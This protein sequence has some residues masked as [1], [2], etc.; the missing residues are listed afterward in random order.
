MAEDTIAS[1]AA[2]VSIE[3]SSSHEST[4]QQQTETQSAP[5][6]QEK[7]LKQSEVNELVGKLK[8]ESYERGLKDGSVK[9][10]EYTPQST[11]ER[12][13][14]DTLSDDRVRNI[15][16]DETEKQTQL[17]LAQKVANEFTQK[18]IAAK[19][20]NKY[21]DFEEKVMQ[22][23]L[24]SIPHI[25]GWANSLDNTADVLYDIAKDPVKFANV[26]MLSQTAPHLAVQQLQKL[27]NSIKENENA[28][29]QPSAA[30]PLSQ[31]KPSA[32]GTD[33]GSMSIKDYRKQSWLKG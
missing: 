20:S 2:P 31:L 23:N 24:P 14:T 7:M 22:L 32:T 13:T 18:I 21:P 1:T 8:R 27:S 17:A 5:V 26:L 3:T 19:D 29:K 12:S 9:Q 11:Q 10:P 25:V 33:N 4:P 28:S 6:P 16:R 30:E 15:I